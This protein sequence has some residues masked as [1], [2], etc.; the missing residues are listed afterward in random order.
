MKF[1][2]WNF[3]PLSLKQDISCSADCDH[4][5]PIG[6]RFRLQAG[7]YEDTL[8]YSV[9]NEAQQSHCLDKHMSP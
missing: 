8:F 9:Q 7:V 2:K 3:G 1:Y 5:F 6:D 4:M